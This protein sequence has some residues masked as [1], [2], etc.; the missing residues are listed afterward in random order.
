MVKLFKIMNRKRFV[1]VLVCF[2]LSLT[3]AIW[4]EQYYYRTSQLVMDV[5]GFSN[6]LDAKE[7]LAAGILHDIRYS[8]TKNNVSVL[9]DDK[10][11]YETSKLNDLSF[12]VYEGEELLFWSNDIVDVSNVDKFPFK[13]TFFLKTN[14]TYCECIQ[15]FHKKYRYVALIKIK[16]CIYP[17]RNSVN[18]HYANGFNVPGNVMIA[19]DTDKD[20]CPIYDVDGQYLFSLVK[21]PVYHYDAMLYWCCIASWMLALLSL[22]LLL[23]GISKRY[24]DRVLYLP[25]FL[26][27]SAFLFACLFLFS[28]FK[29]P[30]I[31]FSGKIFSPEY[32]ASA[33]APSFGHLL[34]YTL[35]AFACLVI[36]YRRVSFNFTLSNCS[37]KNRNA[38]TLGLQLFSS[39]LFFLFYSLSVNLIYNSGMDVAVVLVRDIS[40]ETICSLF[41]II[42][43]FFFWGLI[44]GKLRKMYDYDFLSLRRI[45]FSR[46]L[47]FFL[48]LVVFAIFGN[49]ID[50]MVFFFFFFITFFVD[51]YKHYYKNTTFLYLTVLV[52]AY[53]CMIVGL[54][55]FHSERNNRMKYFTMAENLASGITVLQDR[56]AESVIRTKSPDIKND[57]EIQKLMTDSLNPISS[58]RIES[59][60]KNKYF[61]RFWNKYDIRVQVC[62][63]N[64]DIELRKGVYGDAVKCQ[65][66]FL[67]EKCIPLDNTNFYLNT[68]ELLSLCYIG[69]FQY[70]DYVLYVKFFPNV[71]YNRI[72]FLEQMLLSN[73]DV[74]DTKLSSAKYI[75]NE[76]LFVSG[77]Y[78]Y[79]N[80]LTW[81]P[82]V[83]QDDKSVFVQ[84]GYEHYVFRPDSDCVVVVSKEKAQSYAY[85]IIVSYLFSAYLLFSLLVILANRARER[86]GSKSLLSRMQA[87]F[88]IPMLMSSVVL[89]ALSVTYFLNQY[90]K[91]Q[92]S[93]LSLK[94]NSMQQNLQ[95]R[96]GEGESLS[97]VPIEDVNLMLRDVSNLFHLDIML[98]DNNGVLYSSSR[99]S[100]HIYGDR[101]GANLMSPQ[102]RFS[103]QAEFFQ[104]ENKVDS[105]CLSYYVRAYNRKNVPV[106]YINLLSS[107]AAVQIKNDMMN[108][109]VVIVDIYL[110][111]MMLS[112]FVI[113]MMNKRMT[114]PIAVMAERF[115]EIK[116]TG[117]N[118][119]IDYKYD[120][121][122]GQLVRQYN[123]MVDE[124][125]ISAEKLAKS[126]REF[127][128]R[129]M[130]RRI[131][132]EIKNPLTPM[133]LSVQQAM[134]KKAIDPEHFDEYFAKTSQVII[135]Q[136]DN[137]SR[138][139]S[140]FSS[141]AK[142][143]QGTIERIDLVEK[144]SSSVSLFENNAEEVRFSLRLNGF[145]HG[146]VMADGKQML[147]VFNNLFKNAIQAIP[148]D[149]DGQIEVSYT[150]D[151]GCALISVKDNG[152]G[153]PEKNKDNLFLPNFTTKTSGM[154]LGLA[155]VK[156]IIN[157]SNGTIW[158]DS[159]MN[160]GSV[161]YVKLPL[162]KE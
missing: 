35:Y 149:R 114:K 29:V 45:F 83:R 37:Q 33:M 51:I 95:E 63:K 82:E 30:E 111:I 27:L 139:A 81:L 55:F 141:F 85:A 22:F 135:E 105:D 87:L 74:R 17:K 107:A 116:L 28:Y 67:K 43:W 25:S 131:A 162:L 102:A 76:L 14:N 100:F 142:T 61:D 150:E 70:G 71:F 122:I 89:G 39:L 19:D 18:N 36:A 120:D 108:I 66:S 49:H 93:E 109:L 2:V 101:T 161:F 80:A 129:E 47:L 52:L 16:D 31:L 9:Y 123:K 7:T 138:I 73:E 130:A 40:A 11:L 97:D 10:K 126:E 44:N 110:I 125:M 106:G 112:I 128:W 96:L 12:M 156:N 151:N 1:A 104:E 137:L 146:Y 6:V 153:V 34:L 159:T 152:S 50:M 21:T 115:K 103:N 8:V 77:D 158:F 24:K 69:A 121:E 136:I 54:C 23:Y 86:K 78:R 38:L 117:Q 90:K 143:T 59:I 118:T 4:L 46:L 5:D 113:W 92:I 91:K 48:W 62:Y 68:D 56:V 127:A 65:P 133:K 148:E 144:L 79:P 134:R 42:S 13:K 132:H 72:S 60:V 20:V 154:G 145:E 57:R 53:V 124:L 84:N 26:L 119:K 32:Y 3:S 58:D 88:V 157:S 15:L 99:A 75:K 41:L 98:Y 147:Q 155:I 64:A 160:V 94:A 140:E